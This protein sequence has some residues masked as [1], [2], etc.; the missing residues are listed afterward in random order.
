MENKKLQ[1]VYKIIMLVVI[2][3]LLTFV[4]TTILNYD[5]AK[6]YL[7]STD[8][9]LSFSERLESAIETI[10]ELI[11]EKYMGEVEEDALIEGA[12]K[13]M[14]EALGDDYTEYYTKDEL[15]EFTTTTLGNYVGIGIYMY[16]DTD[17]DTIVIQSPIED[18]PAEEAG[19]QAGDIILKVDG[20]EY[21]A[22]DI[23]DIS[24]YIKGKEGTTVT[25]TIQRGDEIFD[26][27]VTRASVHINYVYSELLDDN[28]GYIYIET[29]D[30]GCA[31]DFLEAYQELAEQG[32]EAL[33]IDLR[34]NGGGVVNEATA[35]ADLICDKGDTLLITVDK[36]GNSKTTVAEEKPTIDMPIVVLTNSSTAS[37][38][39]ILAAALRDNGK[40]EIVGTTTYGK[41]VIQELI[42]LSNG[43]ALKVTTSEYYTPNNEKINGVGI[44][45]DY[46]V[47][48][49][50]EQLDKA[51]EVLEAALQ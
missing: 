14:V 38:S 32:A 42:Y 10:N 9:S 6:K 15:E 40:A 5:G 8:S 44:D 19:I 25:L 29:F 36:D 4:V 7:I 24:T 26:V 27:E 30:E 37:A 43:G 47:T 31:D 39:E 23:N 35:I 16:A 3:A 28:I 2:V 33:I 46:E 1:K 21:T 50:S 11:E 12:I 22:D 48:E 20:I 13:G 45:P 51:L 49:L 18:S 34:Y 41:G 17:N